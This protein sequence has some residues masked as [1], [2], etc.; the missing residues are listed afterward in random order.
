LKDQ[1]Q[2]ASKSS[3]EEVTDELAEWEKELA[4]LQDLLPIDATRERL[5]TVEIPALEAQKSDQ[6]ALLPDAAASAEKV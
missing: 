4:R 3:I 2:K 1:I 5:K 6:E